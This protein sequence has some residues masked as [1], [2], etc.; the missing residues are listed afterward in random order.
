MGGESDMSD[1]SDMSGM[2][3]MSDM[4][5]M[6]DMPDL[7]TNWIRFG[8][9]LVTIWLRVFEYGYNLVAKSMI[10]VTFWLCKGASRENFGYA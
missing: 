3:E 1:M 2:S 9:V 8:Y 6:S 7:V 10:L 5:D 4:S